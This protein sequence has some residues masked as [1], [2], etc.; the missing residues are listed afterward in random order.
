MSGIKL[1]VVIATYNRR[2]SLQRTVP[3]LLAQ[4]LAPEDYELIFVVDGSTDG[5]AEMLR[6][7]KP[8]CA[9]RVLGL[10]HRGPAAARNAGIAAAVG[11]LLVFLDDD[12]ICPP[13]HLRHHCEAHPNLDP[14]ILHGPI[15]VA[16]DSPKTL[17]R[18]AT[19]VW[20]EACY[21]PIVPAVGLQFPI[22]TSSIINSSMPR[23]LLLACGGFDE[24]F[25]AQEDYELGLRLWKMGAQFQFLPGAMAYEYFVKPSQRYVQNDG[26]AY[27]RTEVWLCRK[28]PEHRP[29]SRLAAFGETSSW[30]SIPRRVVIQFPIS[31]A[32]ILRAPIWACERM[33]RFAAVRKLG[34]RFLAH[35]RRL[36][37]LRSAIKEAGSW[38]SFQNEFAV[39]LPVLMYHHVGPSR[40]G[41]FPEWTVSPRQFERQMRWLAHRG[42]TGIRPSDWIKWLRE[43]TGLPEKPILLTFDDGYEDLVEYA[44]PVLRRHGFAAAVFIV[45]ARVGGT[46]TWD[47]VQGS[48]THRLMT[49]EQIRYWATQGIEFGAHSRTHVDLTTLSAS[50]ME[51]EIIGSRDDLAKI[52][53]APVTSFAYPFGSYNQAVEECARRAFGITFRADEQT[54]GVN[55][56]HTGQFNLQRTTVH[57]TDS[58]ADLECRVRW[59]Y[60]PIHERRGRL[61]LRSRF[62]T[63]VGSVSSQQDSGK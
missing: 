45:T 14:L 3:A 29:L 60:S 17:T 44:L 33:F 15:Y 43:G 55:Y 32:T 27:G 2:H 6:G 30:K 39:R 7:Q 51:A 49:A 53:D 9:L 4:D 63:T 35:G 41:T 5:T 25:S 36:T 62:K 59:G 20:Y 21:R 61:R 56:L 54:P 1:S 22:A 34:V 47:E 8:P 26:E 50:E 42:Y 12:L 24:R 52:L 18:H 37:E 58:L 48:A 13:D 11:D 16:P 10:P 23:E 28:H 31:P 40:P 38:K 46:N 57:P 19:E